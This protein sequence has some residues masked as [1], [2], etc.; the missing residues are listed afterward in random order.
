[1]KCPRCSQEYTKL[2][3]S[4]ICLFCEDNEANM[5]LADKKF[6]T[7]V[8]KKSM[9]NFTLQK[10]KV[11]D[12]VNNAFQYANKFNPETDN[13]YLWGNCGTGKT[14]L[15][16]GVAQK[17]Y[18]AGHNVLILTPPDI[19]RRL[20]KLFGNAEDEELESMANSKVLIIDDLGME[21]SSDYLLE[22]LYEIV[23]RRL[24]HSRNGLVIT[25]NMPL[26]ALSKKFGDSRLASRIIGMSTVIEMIGDD[27]RF[28]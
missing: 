28:Y 17:A 15:A 26:E 24:K 1:M 13:L 6:E 14:H 16:V 8:G 27:F 4:G 2:E 10:F 9:E 12:G 11:F 19:R 7:M 5:K 23:N 3:E 25:S 18:Y 21:K 22:K 20:N